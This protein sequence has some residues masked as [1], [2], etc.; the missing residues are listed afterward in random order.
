MFVAMKSPWIDKHSRMNLILLN[1]LSSYIFRGIFGKL[2]KMWSFYNSQKSTKLQ[3]WHDTIS[4]SL[5]VMCYQIF[6]EFLSSP[7]LELRTI[8]HYHSSGSFHVFHIYVYVYYINVDHFIDKIIHKIHFWQL[9]WSKYM[10][11]I[12]TCCTL[13]PLN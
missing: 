13:A 7:Y 5:P 2:S 8:G 3:I 4:F 6:I 12:I 11:F 10:H 9:A 1:F